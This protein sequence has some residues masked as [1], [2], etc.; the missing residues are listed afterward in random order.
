MAASLSILYLL[1]FIGTVGVTRR[2]AGLSQIGTLSVSDIA[3]SFRWFVTTLGKM[4]VWPIVLVVWLVQSKPASPW[5]AVTDAR[6]RLRVVR[7]EREIA[8][9]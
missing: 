1:G 5:R 2:R 9:S 6:G 3:L 7:V 8:G 4:I